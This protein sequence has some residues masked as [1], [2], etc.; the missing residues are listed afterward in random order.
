VEFFD[1]TFRI[2]RLIDL[3]NK[4][5][6]QREYREN[7]IAD[8][9][10]EIDD[11]VDGLIHWLVEENFKQWQMVNN[12]INQRMSELQK[13]I[14]REEASSDIQIERKKIVDG[15]RRQAQRIIEDFN[16]KSETTQIG[17]DAQIAVAA[18]AAV[19]VGAIGL[20]TLVTILATTASA[21]LTGLLLAGLTATLGMFII[22]TRRTQIKTKFT[23][24]IEELRKSLSESLNKEIEKQLDIVTE[25]IK[26]TI[27]PYDRFIRSEE[28]KFEEI[29]DHFN[30]LRVKTGKLSSEISQIK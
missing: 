8:L 13:R 17:L 27:A 28:K 10:K 29:R 25:N 9:E 24:K 5:R 18:S 16:K 11:K 2:G 21:D 4:E 19:E 22:P 6:I 14:I 23:K 20:G 15:V 3:I 7:V 30:D 26:N 12:K 1:E